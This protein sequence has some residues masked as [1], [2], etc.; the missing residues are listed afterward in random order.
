MGGLLNLGN[1]LLDHLLNR[2]I[3]WLGGPGLISVDLICNND[4]YISALV[5]YHLFMVF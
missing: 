2:S 1:M 3:A 4:A 5:S